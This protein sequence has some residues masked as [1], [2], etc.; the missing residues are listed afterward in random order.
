MSLESLLKSRL[1]SIFDF[2][3]VTFD[4]PSESQEQEAVF[5]DVVKCES[6][7][8]DKREIHDVTAKVHAFANS[9]KLPLG[10]FSKCISNADPAL[11]KEFFFYDFEESKGTYRN[12]VERSLSFRFLFDGQYDPNLGT[13]DELTLSY[14][15]NEE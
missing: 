1:K 6:R 10:Y 5:V 9:E 8:I 7:I 3:K 11:K 15:E 13:L 14:T 4:K 12:I 2:D